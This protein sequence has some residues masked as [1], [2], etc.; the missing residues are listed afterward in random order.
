MTHSIAMCWEN[1]NDKQTHNVTDTNRRVKWL[2]IISIH[3]GGL[4]MQ[5]DGIKFTHRSKIRFFTPQGRLVAPIH[6]KLGRAAG[7]MAWLCKISPQSVHGVWIWPQN[8]KNFHFS[9]KD[10]SHG[11]IVCPISKSFREFYVHHYPTKVFQIWPDSFHRLRSYCWETVCQSFRP[12]FSV[13]PVGKIIR[14]IE[15]W[16]PPFWWSRRA[17]SQCKVWGRSY[18]VRRL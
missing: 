1:I 3:H 17:L 7:H 9:V 12:N 8:I 16:F 4:S 5:A 2:L 15:K 14:W 6:V 10:S 18:N 13:H 11:Q